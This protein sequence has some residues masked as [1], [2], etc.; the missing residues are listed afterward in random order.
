MSK[1]VGT[2]LLIVLVCSLGPAAHAQNKISNI[3]GG[4]GHTNGIATSVIVPFPLAVARDN[5]GDTFILSS[6][7]S[8]VYKL[9]SSGRLTV[10]AGT[11]LQTTT[12]DGG[13][14]IQASF[15]N[16]VG[17]AVDPAGNLLIAEWSQGYIRK[18]NMATG[19][20]T[21]LA[22]TG[23]SG[24]SGDNGPAA[25]AQL[26]NPQ[27]VAVDSLGNIYISDTSNNRIRRIDAVSGNI[28]TIAGNGS[29][30]FAGDNGPAT[31]ASL[32]TPLGIAVDVAGNVYFV[33]HLNYR[34]RRIDSQS[35]II[36]TYA[37]NGAAGFVGDGGPAT[38]A[39]FNLI[40]FGVPAQLA[41]DS[42]DNLF[43]A[44]Q[45]NQRIRE[46]D[47]ATGT[48]STVAGGQYGSGGDGGP[49]LSAQL[50]DPSGVVIDAKRN[51]VIG[52]NDNDRVR[53]VSAQ[54]ST[55]TTVAGN[56]TIGDGGPAVNA[57][58]SFPQG[59]AVGKT[60]N[61][62]IA[63]SSESL[64][65]SVSPG[66][67]ISAVAGLKYYFAYLG[68]DVVATTTSLSDPLSVATDPNGNIFIADYFN[69]R[70]RRVDAATGI[71]TT[72]A[73][74]G[75]AAFSGDS[76]PATSASLNFP[77]SIAFG[78]SGNLFICDAGNQR[79]REV[80]LVTGII[81]TVAGNG[82]TGFAGDSGPAVNASLNLGAPYQGTGG[83][84]FDA[85]GDLFLSDTANNRVRKVDSATG[86]ITTFAG[87]SASCALPIGDGGAATSA[88]FCFPEGLAMDAAGN[89]FVADAFENRVRRVDAT[90][91]TISTIAGNGNIGISANGA[92]ATQTPLA[93]PRD[94][95]LDSNGNLYIV[96]AN[97]GRVSKIALAPTASFSG[98]IS[99]FGLQAIGSKSPLQTLTI[100]NT[101]SATLTITNINMI[102]ST[103]FG[104][105][106]CFANNT[107][108]VAPSQS[109]HFSVYFLPVAPGPQSTTLTITT[110]DPVTPS[111]T[112]ALSGLGFSGPSFN[113]SQSALSFADQIVS[114][115]SPA[116][117]VSI[118][119]TGGS[120]VTISN[121]AIS[122]ANSTDFNQTNNCPVFPATLAPGYSCGIFVTFTPVALGVRSASLVITD[123]QGNFVNAQQTVS[124]TGTGTDV[125]VV[126]STTYN[127]TGN[128]FTTFAGSAA[129]PPDCNISGSFTL[130]QPL[131]PNLSNATI[132]PASFS[133]TV[134]A[135]N[136]T[137]ANVTSATFTGISTDASGYVTSWAISLANANFFI[138]TD[139]EPGNVVD[140][141]TIVTPQ[142]STS[143][144]NSPATWPKTV[145]TPLT[146]S[147]SAT[148]VSNI[149]VLNCPSGTVPCTDP[150][151]HSLKLTVPAVNTGFTLTVT[152]V[153]VP[154][155][156]ANGV[157]EAGNTEANDFDCRFATYFP[158]QVK[159]NG[160]VVVPQCVPYSNGNCI[161]Y[162]V[163]NTPPESYY[164]AGVLEYIAWNNTSYTPLPIYN[165]NNPRLYDDP[166]DPP[167]NL[168]HQFVFDITNYYQPTGE[169]VGLDPG[170]SGQT[171][172][173]NDF[174]VAYPG[175]PSSPYALTILPPLKASKAA[176]FPQGNSIPISF[177]LMPNIPPGVA[178]TPPHRTG[179]S[180]LLD[181][182]NTG[183]SDF[184]GAHQ[185]TMTLPASANNF[186]YDP[187]HQQYNLKLVGIYSPGNYKLLISSDLIPEQCAPF[188]VSK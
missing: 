68:D 90:T 9:D 75:T 27:G 26:S 143:N 25:Q 92:L 82:T 140:S 149:A 141:F 179:Y 139:N 83:L 153:E 177:T 188:T 107:S 53:L 116:Q 52:D 42:S 170:I 145:V 13:P 35:G 98:S 22:G 152:S 86:I 151:A 182:N 24:F 23:V 4:G 55:I 60:G 84:A 37:G 71:I 130:P 57:V 36:T 85:A 33:D 137:Q 14:A 63:D 115:S 160:D 41:F 142:G 69:H 59:V 178:M 39:S 5:N 79:I 173:F 74:N 32:N 91:G 175:V 10:V 51:I 43:V 7:A 87:A 131:P 119:N 30:G 162:R 102:S 6:T 184:S 18:I 58:L 166:D 135:T 95:A 88:S 66:G 112:Y 138:D 67:T 12:G 46:I 65:R 61:V 11:G 44:D 34:I 117:T 186:V 127:I 176:V 77:S 136:L 80:D 62:L 40:G 174:V 50:S 129:C 169:F 185:P 2:P 89:L 97:S 180:V 125:P 134:G 114:T 99:D 172:H 168:N 165:A 38:G 47:A 78:P 48:I 70:I 3:A 113:I 93:I 181:T 73:G 164:T 110:N 94:V 1:V 81:T 128:P 105:T 104:V 118:S 183:C 15:N 148:P 49:A 123:S 76:G 96:Q 103:F 167:Y 54:T 154:I 28:T 159:G 126:A 16:P 147:T 111:Y 156:Q 163:S 108:I 21:T 133:F 171:K 31:A 158:L 29:T 106:D 45:F 72:V 124:L 64:I 20:I 100:T 155:S 19:I 8:S 157:C 187:R 146:F 56:G 150:N 132:I 101:G 121:I 144:S 122:D 17:L 161:Y 109:C 120:A